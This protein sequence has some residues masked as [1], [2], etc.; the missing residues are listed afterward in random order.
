MNAFMVCLIMAAI[1]I[2][3]LYASYIISLWWFANACIHQR[4]VLYTSEFGR[5][6]WQYLIIQ[7]RSVRE[8]LECQISHAG[9]TPGTSALLCLYFTPL[10]V[11]DD[12]FMG[13]LLSLSFALPLSRA[14]CLRDFRV[15]VSLVSPLLLMPTWSTFSQSVITH[16][17]L[18]W[19]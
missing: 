13:C 2:M 14:D 17:C 18:S 15:F 9:V 19:T 1:M 16:V 11:V 5:D 6:M 12:G 10:N 3:S 7:S 8:T 4:V